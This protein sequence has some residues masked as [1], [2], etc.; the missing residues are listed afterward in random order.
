LLFISA[1]SVDLVLLPEMCFYE[2]V[3][4]EDLLCV[5]IVRN[6]AKSRHVIDVHG[7]VERGMYAKS[8]AGTL[9]VALEDSKWRPASFNVHCPQ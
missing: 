5:V 3:T 6:T 2:V 4:L 1:R 7:A 9:P 8:A